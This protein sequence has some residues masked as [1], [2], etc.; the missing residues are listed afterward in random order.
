MSNATVMLAEVTLVFAALPP[1]V[2]ELVML[3]LEALG[4]TLVL[5]AIFAVRKLA[6]KFG[7]QET[8]DLEQLIQSRAWTAV[9]EVEEWAK[10]QANKPN[11]KD[12]LA[13]ALKFIQEYDEPFKLTETLRAKSV[14]FIHAALNE[15]RLPPGE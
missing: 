2:D 7:I 11:G 15:E 5:F 4:G 13:R 10:R 14:A 6:R 1:W 3:T 8:R 12:K 9:R